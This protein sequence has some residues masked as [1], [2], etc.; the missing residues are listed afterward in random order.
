MP[1]TDCWLPSPHVLIMSSDRC[2]RQ[3]AYHPT[4]WSAPPST[5]L[6][7][8]HEGRHQFHPTYSLPKPP[9]SPLML[10]FALFDDFQFNHNRCN[11]LVIYYYFRS[12]KHTSQL[13]S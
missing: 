4:S 3:L 6:F 8:P 2:S 11:I 9:T 13:Q 12:E 7:H 10:F 5:R 1:K